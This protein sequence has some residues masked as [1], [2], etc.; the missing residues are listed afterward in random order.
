MEKAKTVGGS[1]SFAI[2]KQLLESIL[3]VQLG[4]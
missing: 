1:L 2:L 3:K 4:L